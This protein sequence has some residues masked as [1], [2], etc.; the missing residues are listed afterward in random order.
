V[1]TAVSRPLQQDVL[2]DLAA[3]VGPVVSDGEV[4]GREPLG[5]LGAGEG[6][7]A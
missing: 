6:A 5:D 7:S 1:S 4:E 2:A 3:D